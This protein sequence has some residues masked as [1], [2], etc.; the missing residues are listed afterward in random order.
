MNSRI[1]VVCNE[2]NYDQL[3]E[4]EAV[5]KHIDTAQWQVSQS[6]EA[7]DKAKLEKQFEKYADAL[8]GV[9]DE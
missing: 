2:L 8:E 6:L 4:L 7:D 5:K 9:D 1:V 3:H